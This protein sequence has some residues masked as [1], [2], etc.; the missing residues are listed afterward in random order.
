MVLSIFMAFH[1]I[2]LRASRELQDTLK[3][4][5]MTL[6]EHTQPENKQHLYWL[7]PCTDAG[8]S[9]YII[10]GLIQLCLSNGSIKKSI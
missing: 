5:S 2:A 3:I 7:I 8:V 10:T 4:L 1:E 9:S 6:Q